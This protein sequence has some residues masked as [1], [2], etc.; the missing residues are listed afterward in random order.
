MNSIKHLKKNKNYDE[1]IEKPFNFNLQTMSTARR[2]CR[3]SL[4]R[5]DVVGCGREVAEQVKK[6]TS[7]SKTKQKEELPMKLLDDPKISTARQNSRRPHRSHKPLD[8]AAEMRL[9]PKRPYCTRRCHHHLSVVPTNLD[10]KN[11]ERSLQNRGWSPPIDEDRNPPRLH[12]QKTTKT[13]QSTAPPA[14]EAR[15]T[16]AGVRRLA[17]S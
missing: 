11:K 9:K 16:I 5:P 17:V 7:V 6:T 4:S 1:I 8:V 3:S 12:D 15:D 2:R 13:R 14:G 10:T